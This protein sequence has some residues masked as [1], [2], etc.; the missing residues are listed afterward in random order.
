MKATR[1]PAWLN[2]A[3]TAAV[4]ERERTTAVLAASRERTQRAG[5]A[6]E[7]AKA[8][9][10]DLQHFWG[11]RRGQHVGTDPLDALLVQ[12]VREGVMRQGELQQELHQAQA[13]QSDAEVQVRQR[14]AKCQ[15]LDRYSDGLLGAERTHSLKTEQQQQ[16]E[17]WLQASLFA[18]RD[19]TPYER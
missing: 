9:V 1:T 8:Y 10:N 19:E 17:L 6:A 18:S 14:H 2:F 11:E 3:Q 13:V 5:Q 7:Q 4:A 12:A 15:A 16:Q